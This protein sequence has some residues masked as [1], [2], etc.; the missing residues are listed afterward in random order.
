MPYAR[1][2]LVV[3]VMVVMGSLPGEARS[4]VRASEPATVS[5]TVD[6]TVLTVEYSRPRVRGRSP[7]YGKEVVWG[8]VWTPGANWATTLEVSSDVTIDGHALPKGKYS[9]W[10]EVQEGDWT[11]ILDP[12]AKQFHTAH[13][14]PDSSQ[15]RFSVTPDSVAGP[16]VLLWSFPEISTSGMVLQVAW[17]GRAV[18]LPI[19]VPPSRTR[20]LAAELAPRYVGSY[21]LRWIPRD[22]TTA[23]ADSTPP[24]LET[25]LISYVGD[26]LMLKWEVP[27]D[28]EAEPY[29]ALLVSVGGDAFFPGFIEENDYYEEVPG[30]LAEFS[31]TDGRA[32]GF[33]IRRKD[34]TVQAVGTRMP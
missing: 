13:P 1:W 24:P 11:V 18:R 27:D 26:T 14:K 25:W 29:H 12:N 34:D 4:Q 2:M 19:V 28:D 23:S 30:L 8:E 33:V 15:I 22:T 20:T 16:E 32:T 17:A 10:M 9:V 5:Q 21:S 6:G 31:V 3:A 7:I